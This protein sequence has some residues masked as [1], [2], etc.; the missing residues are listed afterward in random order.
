[1]RIR[2]EQ[3]LIELWL[4]G[5]KCLKVF[6]HLPGQSG[7]HLACPRESPSDQCGEMRKWAPCMADA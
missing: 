2:G 1:M 4:G 6:A 7:K 3:F 5:I